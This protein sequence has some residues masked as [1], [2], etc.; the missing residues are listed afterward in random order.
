MVDYSTSPVMLMAD[1][2]NIGSKIDGGGSM[3]R[4]KYF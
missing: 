1:L 3:N 2:E 4:N